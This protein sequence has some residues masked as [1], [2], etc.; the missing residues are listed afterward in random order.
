[1]KGQATFREFKSALCN[2]NKII[3]SILSNHFKKYI[4]GPVIDIGSGVGDIANNAFPDTKAYLIDRNEEIVPNLSKNHKWIVGDFLR[5]GLGQIPFDGTVLLS[6]VIQYLDSDLEQ[7]KRQINKIRPI[8]IIEVRN[9]NT[10]LFWG[11][12]TEL[13]KIVPNH[14]CEVKVDFAPPEMSLVDRK[15]FTAKLTC[16]TFHELAYVIVR[17]IMDAT[18][19]AR[20]IARASNVLDDALERPEL[21][22]PES[23]W[24]HSRMREL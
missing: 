7:L 16:R 5:M 22:I 15:K 14:N 4:V 21:D 13:K 6:H 10:G 19:S 8:N 11:L 20:I 17:F 2:E 3:S 12:I 9:D 18:V 23:V 24:V 1:M